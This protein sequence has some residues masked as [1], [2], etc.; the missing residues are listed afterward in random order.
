MQK[1]RGDRQ[2]GGHQVGQ[3]SSKKDTRAQIHTRAHSQPL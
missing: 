1:A 3:M 2:M